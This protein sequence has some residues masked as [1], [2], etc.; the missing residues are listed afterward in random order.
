MRGR[1]VVNDGLTLQHLRYL[2]AMDEARTM[3]MAA[4]RCRVTPQTMGT[5]LAKIEEIVGF[6]IRDQTPNRT[7]LNA[8]GEV[9]AREMRR[10]IHHIEEGIGLAARH[11][12]AHATGNADDVGGGKVAADVTVGTPHRPPQAHRD[13]ADRL[14]RTLTGRT[15]AVPELLAWNP[16]TI[17]AAAFSG[18]EVVEAREMSRTLASETAKGAPQAFLEW[19]AHGAALPWERNAKDWR[20]GVVLFEEPF[21]YALI[22][23]DDPL[24][25]HKSLSAA[26]LK[27][28]IALLSMQ[29]ENYLTTKQREELEAEGLV[30]W[31]FLNGFRVALSKARFESWAFVPPSVGANPPPGLHGLRLDDLYVRS[32]LY[33][34]TR[35]D[36]APPDAAATDSL[37]EK[38][39]HALLQ[40]N[41][42]DNL[43]NQLTWSMTALR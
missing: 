4:K 6:P 9:L 40:A 33:L 11:H 2:V 25:T 19:R 23:D 24:A 7:R 34:V 15:I 39:R 27:G 21:S 32:V 1:A 41:P 16:T 26:A 22:R 43:S 29:C 10:A 42:S 31:R 35:R 3:T 20:R 36:Q 17:E 14:G 18:F 28:R 12:R 5:Q 30:E 38:L 8:A 37:A 13:S